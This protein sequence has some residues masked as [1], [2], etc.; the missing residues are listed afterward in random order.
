ME[1]ERQPIAALR[2]AWLRLHAEGRRAHEAAAALGVTEA[3]LV[4]STCTGEPGPMR[5]TPLTLDEP[6]ILVAAFQTLGVVKTQTRSE[7]VVLEVVG[8]YPAEE[9]EAR[10][11]AW[12]GLFAVREGGARAE[13]KSLQLFDTAGTPIQK[14]FLLGES[15][16]DAFERLVRA[17]RCADVAAIGSASAAPLALEPTPADADSWP[18]R[19]LLRTLTGAR[20]T[21]RVLV[22]NRGIHH[23]HDVTLR[24]MTAKNDWLALVDR[25]AKVLIHRATRAH[26]RRSE[27]LGITLSGDAGPS[28]LLTRLPEGVLGPHHR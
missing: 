25:N 13:R 28:A 20:A 8:P 6:A 19:R 17:R 3:D 22:D 4:A 10:A 16:V 9:V 27:P 23:E 24:R 12:G 18:L 7:C 14:L 21:I 15:D 2:E 11:D 1:G 26:A 5:A